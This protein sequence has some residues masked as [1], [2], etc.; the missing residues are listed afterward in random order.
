MEMVLGG[1][2]EMKVSKVPMTS[3]EKVFL[4]ASQ[5]LLS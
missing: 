2:E 3:F 4:I 5:F 1:K